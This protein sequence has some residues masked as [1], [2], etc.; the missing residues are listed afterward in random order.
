MSEVLRERSVGELIEQTL[1][2][3]FRNF[4]KLFTIWIVF[5]FALLL[6]CVPF[7]IIAAGSAVAGAPVV[8][9]VVGSLLF[10]GLLVLSPLP[11]AAAVI[12]I[13]DNFTGR[14]HSVMECYQAV[15]PFIGRLIL[16]GFV[17]GFMAMIGFLLFV[18]PGVIVILVYF[19]SYPALL[20]EDLS[21]GEAMGRSAELTRDN[22]LRLLGLLIC[23][24][25]IVG[26]FN[27]ISRF[28]T[29][30]I[31]A[32]MP[33]V[34]GIVLSSLISMV[35]STIGNLIQTCGTVAAYFDLRVRKD[36]FHL[37]QLAEI[38]DRISPQE[39]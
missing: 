19:V 10:V 16:L 1:S 2:L 22:R 39:R 7:G 14:N 13:S 28:L 32:A 29:L 26:V 11:G 25:V 30:G 17:I 38:V 31:V 27:M 12:A 34:V 8:A 4:V 20:L 6:L 37:E 33:G 35:I 3:V 15:F 23:L 24:F 18:I 36:A 9:I 5:A 21:V